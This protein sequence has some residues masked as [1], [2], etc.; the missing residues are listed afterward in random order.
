MDPLDRH[1]SARP[2]RRRIVA[3]SDRTASVMDAYLP[4]GVYEDF[5]GI[6]PVVPSNP[7]LDM[8]EENSHETPSHQ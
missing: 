1:R 8:F 6:R 3:G 4:P 5:M 7:T 2:R